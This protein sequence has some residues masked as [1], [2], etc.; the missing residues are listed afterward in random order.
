[1]TEKMLKE[2]NRKMASATMI[3]GPKGSFEVTVN[4]KLVFS[5]LEQGRF[6]DVK[7]VRGA[8]KA[9]M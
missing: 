5:K 9:A 1:M 2:F 7:E 3:P 6:P 4:G 8:L